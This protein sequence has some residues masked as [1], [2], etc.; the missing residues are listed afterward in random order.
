MKNNS[1][2]KGPEITRMAGKLDSQNIPRSFIYHYQFNLI[3]QNPQLDLRIFPQELHEAIQM[4]LSRGVCG[5]SYRNILRVNVVALSKRS[6][7]LEVEMTTTEDVWIKN[8]S[9]YYVKENPVQLRRYCSLS[10]PTRL[11]RVTIKK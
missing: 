5:Q 3:N 8:L 6:F 9:K 11:F 4:I 1:K 2:K 10:D 7:E